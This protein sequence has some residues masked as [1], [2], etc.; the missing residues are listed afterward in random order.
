[1]Q[2][3]F[4]TRVSG[5]HNHGTSVDGRFK[6]AIANC[7]DNCIVLLDLSKAFN[8]V[9]N[10]HIHETFKSFSIPPESDLTSIH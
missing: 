5:A 4:V 1:M 6:E 2:H 8:S 9:G 3:G 10:I 7:R